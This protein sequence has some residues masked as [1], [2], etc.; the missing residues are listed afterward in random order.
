[1]IT[2]LVFNEGRE[3]R[4]AMRGFFAAK[5]T[6]QASTITQN[7]L[8]E[9]YALIPG[10]TFEGHPFTSFGMKKTP[11]TNKEWREVAESLRKKRFVLLNHNDQT[12]ET[13]FVRKGETIEQVMEGGQSSCPNAV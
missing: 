4:A 8:S 5:P 10:D 1:M 6:L 11:V 12:G 3:E 13:R 7:D 2:L 9:G